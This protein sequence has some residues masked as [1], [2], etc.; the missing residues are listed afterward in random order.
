MDGYALVLLAELAYVLFQ[1]GSASYTGGKE[2]AT[3]K[4]MLCLCQQ[5]A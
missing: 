4:K 2:V 1:N 5:V 3:V